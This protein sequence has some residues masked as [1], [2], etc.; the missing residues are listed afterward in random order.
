MSVT[1]RERVIKELIPDYIIDIISMNYNKCFLRTSVIENNEELEMVY[2]TDGYSKID[3]SKCTLKDALRI[4]SKL[5]IYEE[6]SENHLIFPED[7]LINGDMIYIKNDTN[8]IKLIYYPDSD[9]N[10]LYI[11]LKEL[12]EEI[13]D[14][15][16]YGEKAI[17][18]SIMSDVDEDNL[19]TL[20]L[21][22]KIE[23]LLANMSL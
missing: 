11:K 21:V 23:T 19:N 8:E 1:R 15:Y 5:I 4:I 13:A 12:I 10:T 18:M 20:S 16:Q 6:L 2:H 3:Y 9:N 17:I 14:H 7:Y 22:N